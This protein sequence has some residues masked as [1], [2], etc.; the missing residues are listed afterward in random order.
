M[1]LTGKKLN[2]ITSCYNN[3]NCKHCYVDAYL[4]LTDNVYNKR[5]IAR[6]FDYFNSKGVND[7]SF[8]GGEPL[9]NTFRLMEMLKMGLNYFQHFSLLTNGIM[10]E[11][12]LLDQLIELGLA[13]LKISLFS[14]NGEEFNSLAGLIRKMYIPK[15]IIAYANSKLTT[16]L[17]VPIFS[18]KLGYL[19]S[20]VFE[21][22]DDFMAS[23]NSKN[24]TFLST[25]PNQFETMDFYKNIT[26]AGKLIKA[27]KHLEIFNTGKYN[28][29]FLDIVSYVNEP[30]RFYLYPDLK[31]RTSLAT[32][33]SIYEI[34][35][36]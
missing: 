33:D 20:N 31:V 34:S 11:E 12:A 5:E 25:L 29:G 21:G 22:F 16:I 36:G 8:I 7:V 27:E 30:G 6:I 32:L 26:A 17:Y 14:F 35:Q 19:N 10:L 24:I 1:E 4:P 23:T 15:D 18:S 2:I 3:L 9:M 28:I 13:E